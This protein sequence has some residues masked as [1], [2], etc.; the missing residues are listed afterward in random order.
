MLFR[1]LDIEIGPGVFE[2]RPQT[3]ALVEMGAKELMQRPVEQRIAVDLGAGSAALA[4][5]LGME[6]PGARVT[7]VEV[8]PVASEWAQKNIERLCPL[9]K[10][11][12]SD[13]T[14][15]VADARSVADP[16]GPL[17]NLVGQV[18]VIVANPPYIPGD[19]NDTNIFRTE[20]SVS[21]FGGPDGL[22]V[23]RGFLRTATL[24]LRPGG[25]F[26][27]EHAAHQ[28]EDAGESGAPWMFREGTTAAHW[29]DVEVHLDL[30]HRQR[31]TSARLRG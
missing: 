19:P 8:D 5:A 2:P 10:E 29:V 17:A 24:L 4:L 31:Y 30:Y 16:D 23:A 1:D 14:L 27:M 25:F 22:D 11:H 21:L 15:V 9:M 13:V 12:G 18:D 6:V 28:G 7:A 3:E 26:V 20:P